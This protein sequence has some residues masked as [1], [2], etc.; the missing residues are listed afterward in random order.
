M[1]IVQIRAVA[2]EYV[3]PAI[4]VY[5]RA[6]GACPRA[7]V[8]GI[9]ESRRRDVPET[10]VRVVQQQPIA[11]SR[12]QLGVINRRLKVLAIPHYPLR[13]HI[14]ILVA[15]VVH[16]AGYNARAIARGGVRARLYAHLAERR[17][18]PAAHIALIAKQQVRVAHR[19]RDIEIHIPVAVIVKDNHARQIVGYRRLIPQRLR[20]DIPERRHIPH[21]RETRP[22]IPPRIHANPATRRRLPRRNLPRNLP[23]L[24]R[25]PLPARRRLRLLVALSPL[26]R[27][28]ALRDN[29]LRLLR[30]RRRR[31]GNN[32]RRRLNLP[33]AALT[34]AALAI[35]RIPARH[36]ANRYNRGY[37]HDG[38]PP[39]RQRN[40]RLAKN[41]SERA[42]HISHP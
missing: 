21:A 1:H 9:P 42:P 17:R 11:D 35:P 2:Y 18:I 20:R 19:L 30:Q 23:L 12:P 16:I 37:K 26:H 40:A 3:Y 31:S 32:Y 29:R 7:R 15:V 24:A 14:Q 4:P 34:Y 36:R 38:K 8:R 13:A 5:V 22:P 6:G 39:Q 33:C 10:A 25:L 41:E 28:A 27:R